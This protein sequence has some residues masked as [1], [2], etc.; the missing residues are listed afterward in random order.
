MLLL[1]TTSA[2]RSTDSPQGL[3]RAVSDSGEAQ[4]KHKVR[5]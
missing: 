5:K 2:T 3:P 1:G 4:G